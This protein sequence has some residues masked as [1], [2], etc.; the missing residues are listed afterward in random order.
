MTKVDEALES[1]REGHASFLQERMLA[2]LRH[3]PYLV[4][5]VQEFLL[6]AEQHREYAFKQTL[7]LFL[8]APG[9]RVVIK[10]WQIQQ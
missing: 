9:E 6:F 7:E 2:P 3:Q 10:P 8:T 5:W 4:R 1:V